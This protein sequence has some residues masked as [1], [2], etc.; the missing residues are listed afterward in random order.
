MA[1]SRLNSLVSLHCLNIM[2]APCII[3]ARDSE[4]KFPLSV[5]FKFG[6][7]GAKGMFKSVC[8]VINGLGPALS[9]LD[10]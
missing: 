1:I 2:D 9:I 7:S 4:L 6:F 5:K 10:F 8:N 3:I